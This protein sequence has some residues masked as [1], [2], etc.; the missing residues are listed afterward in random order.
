MIRSV[1]E[2]YV[3]FLVRENQKRERKKKKKERK[4]H[5]IQKPKEREKERERKKERSIRFT[6]PTET[7]EEAEKISN[8]LRRQPLFS[9]HKSPLPFAN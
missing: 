7:G 2:A 9:I 4:K 5:S 1:E 8:D 6:K 3:P